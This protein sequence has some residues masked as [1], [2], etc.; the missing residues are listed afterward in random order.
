MTDGE[1][2]VEIMSDV[3]R[4]T[5]F[6]TDFESGMLKRLLTI[7]ITS[8]FIRLVSS[9]TPSI[10]YR[11]SHS[12]LDKLQL[13]FFIKETFHIQTLL[14]WFSVRLMSS[15]GCGAH[16]NMGLIS[17]E[18]AANHKIP[19]WQWVLDAN[20]LTSAISPLWLLLSKLSNHVTPH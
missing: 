9:Y 16:V 13:Y 14:D 3:L 4:C 10:V 20:S 1:K 15:R 12:W 8:C 7:R 11:F 5:L 6:F 18:L 2:K 19:Q 17:W